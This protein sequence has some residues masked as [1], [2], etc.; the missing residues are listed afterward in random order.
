MRCLRNVHAQPGKQSVSSPSRSGAAVVLAF[1]IAGFSLNALAMQSPRSI[2]WG[3]PPENF[4][5][6][7]YVA[8][9]GRNPESTAVVLAWARYATTPQGKLWVFWQFR[10]SP[11]YRHKYGRRPAGYGG[12]CGPW[13]KC[14]TVYYR[15]NQ[16]GSKDYTVS[17]GL[18]P[19]GY[20]GVP[21]GGGP[22]EDFD[23]AI[24]IR[25]YY[26]AFGG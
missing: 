3:Y 10:N 14:W 25:D 15:V 22:Y 12:G 5:H 7:L 2:R 17:N 18:L 26:A 6:S 13:I 24:A 8:V 20:H 11:E 16:N 23:T 19:R 4:V 21:P 9:L 1:L